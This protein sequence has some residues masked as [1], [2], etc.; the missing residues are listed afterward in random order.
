[1]IPWD[2]YRTELKRTCYLHAYIY[3]RIDLKDIVYLLNYIA[4]LFQV[5]HGLLFP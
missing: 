1:M 2:F 5:L 4:L 3:S